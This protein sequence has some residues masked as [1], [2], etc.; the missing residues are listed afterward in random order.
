MSVNST[1]HSVTPAQ[2]KK[3]RADNELF[4]ALCGYDEDAP[5]GSFKAPSLDLS[6]WEDTHTL[7]HYAGCPTAHKVLNSDYDGDEE[8]EYDGHDIRLATPAK[9]KKIAEELARVTLDVLRKKG[10]EAE[11][12]TFRRSELLKPED[13]EEQFDE[14]KRVRSFFETAAKAGNAILLTEG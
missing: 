9:V 12:K 6:F 4:A 11:Y 14:V 2:V 5:E 1:L 13:Y 7:L 10:L 8:L 3:L